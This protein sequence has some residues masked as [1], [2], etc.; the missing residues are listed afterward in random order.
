MKR[1]LWVGWARGEQDEWPT[2]ERS[3]LM[4][5]Y[6]LHFYVGMLAIY[7]MLMLQHSAMPSTLSHT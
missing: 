4:H 7:A 6:C 1:L 2:V 3:G 5:V